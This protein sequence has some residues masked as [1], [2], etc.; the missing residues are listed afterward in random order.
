MRLLIAVLVVAGA[1]WL[2]GKPWSQ[3]ANAQKPPPK[4]AF[5]AN[6]DNKLI[7]ESSGVASSLRR[8]GVY[9][10]HNDSGG[11]AELFAF[12]QKGKDLGTYT[13]SG[14]RAR[15]W[16]DMAS[17]SVNGTP[18]VYIGDIGDNL[19]D[20]KQL[21]IYRF[22]EPTV[23]DSKTITKY[24][25]YKVSYPDGSHNAEA[26]MVDSGGDVYIVTKNDFGDSGLYRLK[27]PKAAGSFTLEKVAELKIEGGNVYSHRVTGGDISQDGK[28]VVL[29]TYFSVL[30][31]NVENIADMARV[32]P[33]SL[34]VPLER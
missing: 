21:R 30:L 27:S 9:W 5:L 25:T 18:Y 26:L 17:R 3:T 19:G 22:I 12:D 32:K 10:T 31:Y 4:S 15:D 24:E 28:H 1:V 14:V 8:S 11:K 13:I 23:S 7:D 16:E 33:V 2:I 34:P 29:R 6:L 20:Q